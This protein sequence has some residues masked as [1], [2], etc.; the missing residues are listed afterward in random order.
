M[1][2]CRDPSCIDTDGT[3]PSFRPA[4]FPRSPGVQDLFLRDET[5]DIQSMYIG[6]VLFR[7]PLLN[8]KTNTRPYQVFIINATHIHLLYAMFNS[9]ACGMG[10]EFHPPSKTTALDSL[11]NVLAKLTQKSQWFLHIAF[12]CTWKTINL[13]L[14]P[15]SPG[16]SFVARGR[17][18]AEPRVRTVQHKQELRSSAS[19]TS[20]LG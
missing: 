9:Y 8:L 16:P 13:N 14:V 10:D 3:V 6:M 4:D 11:R 7:V 12:S 5:C 2:R 19:E 18:V 15:A 20:G 1:S 17:D